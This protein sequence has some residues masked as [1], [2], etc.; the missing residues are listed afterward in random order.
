[1]DGGIVVEVDVVVG[2]VVVL[3]ELDVVGG[4]VVVGATVVVGGR[5][6]TVVVEELAFRG[7]S[8]ATAATKK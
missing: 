8:F 7:G 4:N 6:A 3:D 1:V 2:G 5:V